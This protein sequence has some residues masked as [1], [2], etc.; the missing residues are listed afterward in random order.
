MTPDGGFSALI[1]HVNK[2]PPTGNPADQSINAAN[3]FQIKEKNRKKKKIS[4]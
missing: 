4:R 1:P 2:K 3:N